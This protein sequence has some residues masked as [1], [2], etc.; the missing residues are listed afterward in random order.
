[1]AWQTWLMMDER[2]LGL[3]AAG[4]A[5]YGFLSIFPAMAAGIAVFGYMADPVMIS[6]QMAIAENLLPAEAYSLLATQIAALVTANR[7][8]LQLTTVVS[9]LVA[10]F[11]ARAAVAS[12]IRGL[13]A[14]YT[15]P[16]RQ[17]F[18][19]RIGVAVLLTA[20]LILVMLLA[21]GLV[22][23]APVA[24]AF[25]NLSSTAA[26]ALTG[27]KWT[28]L[29][30]VVFFAVALLYRYGPNR[31]GA[32]LRWITPGSVFA[33]LT[34]AAGSYA[35]TTYVRNFDRLNE[36][37]G[38]LGAVVALLLWFYI[39]ALVTLLGAQLNAELELLTARDTTH[40]PDRPVGRRGAFV[41]DHRRARDGAV[42]AA[43]QPVETR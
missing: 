3:I 32:R 5:F 1:M 16:H 18:F 15:Q 30:A 25:L 2:N 36:V 17:N 41:A 34:W 14:I 11:S 19:R 24:L 35:L 29:I 22:V 7:S 13:N 8:T 27:L 28:V 38:S 31:R 43:D 20:L 21:I 39:S 10:I 26:L 42:R 9:I 6:D 4:V 40:G 37:Y 33:V 23:L 12:L